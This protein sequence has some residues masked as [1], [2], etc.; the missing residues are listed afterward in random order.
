MKPEIGLFKSVLL[1]TL[2]LSFVSCKQNRKFTKDEWL[3]EV[4]FPVN[5][6]RNKMVDDLLNN[7]LNKPLSYQEVLG[8]LGEPFNKDS[9]SFSVS[10][11]TYIEYEWLGID[12][13]Q[14]NYLDISFGQ[15]SILK[16]AKARIWNKKY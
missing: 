2:M 5:N 13:S 10:Y 1:F 6:E 15:D 4:D 12:E 8:L 3:K 11:I 9:L 14:I 7:Y 16:E